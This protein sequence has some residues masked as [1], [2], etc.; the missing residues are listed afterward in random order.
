VSGNKALRIM[1]YNDES[2]GEKQRLH[3]FRGTYR[4]LVN[5]H[6]EKHNTSLEAKEAVLDHHLGS[7]VERAYTNKSN[8]VE[9]MRRLLEWYADYLEEL[10]NG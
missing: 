6:Q 7:K 8:Y 10:K 9:Q 5:T 1:G 3:S 4:S 2:K